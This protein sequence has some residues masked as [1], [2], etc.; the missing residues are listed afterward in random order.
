MFSAHLPVEPVVPVPVPPVGL[1]L[2]REPNTGHFLLLPTTGLGER[3]VFVWFLFVVL[4]LIYLVKIFD[5]KQN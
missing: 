4:N 2:V 1:Q 5:A 3:F